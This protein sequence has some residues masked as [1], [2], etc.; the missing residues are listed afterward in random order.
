MLKSNK[1]VVARSKHKTIYFFIHNHNLSLILRNVFEQ[2]LLS[3]HQDA[4]NNN[5]TFIM[6]KLTPTKKKLIVYE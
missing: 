3:C 5:K 6:L 1:I 4:K 2:F